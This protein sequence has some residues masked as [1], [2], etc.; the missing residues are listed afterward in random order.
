M[1]V[2]NS[3]FV[4]KVLNINVSRKLRGRR[5]AWQLVC[6]CLINPPLFCRYLM[7][8]PE[9]SSESEMEVDDKSEEEVDTK[10][11]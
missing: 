3:N 8:G 2:V 11:K 6:W 5:T 1:V 10:V 9:S 4:N 7:D